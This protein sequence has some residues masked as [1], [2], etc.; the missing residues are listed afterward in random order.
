MVPRWMRRRGGRKPVRPNA[1]VLLDRVKALQGAR[2]GWTVA[3]G[4]DVLGAELTR[5]RR[6]E[7]SLSIIVLST[8]PLVGGKPAHDDDTGGGSSTIET[9]LPQIVSLISAQALCEM[10][11]ESDVVHYQSAGD[12]FVLG[13]LEA[14]N[15]ES[16]EALG[17]IRASFRTR[18]SLE[19]HAGVAVFPQDG[20][21]LE[22]LINV[23]ADRVIS[24]PAVLVP[25]GPQPEAVRP[26]LKMRAQ[27]AGGD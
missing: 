17:R 15:E 24:A 3:D 8:T 18:L 10:L 19:V 26:V 21:T 2:G 27:A 5:A 7:C 12:R 23:A 9:H 14:G 25:E 4:A 1:H 16:R 6:Y 13:L 11:R 20:L 22:D